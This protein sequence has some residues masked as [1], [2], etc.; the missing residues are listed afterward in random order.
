MAWTDQCKID[1]CKQVEHRKEQV[2]GIRADAA[3][4]R[5][6]DQAVKSGKRKAA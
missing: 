1:A 5:V 6:N 2:G 3:E 4:Q